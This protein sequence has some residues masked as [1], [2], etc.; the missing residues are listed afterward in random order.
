MNE[1]LNETAAGIS[2]ALEQ[3]D[4]ERRRIGL[5]GFTALEKLDPETAN[6]AKSLWDDPQRAADW[7]TQEIPSL[8]SR[9]PWECIA[10]G[11]RERVQK[12]LNAI[13]YG[14]PA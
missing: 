8:G 10:V 13:A 4:A 2:S 1:N 9:T 14:V 5:D 7:F 11:E 3:L 6:L 12:T